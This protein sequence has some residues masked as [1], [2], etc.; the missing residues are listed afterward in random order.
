[1][2]V[3]QFRGVLI[4]GFHYY[5]FFTAPSASPSTVIV[6]E[7]TWSTISLQWEMVECL[8][9]NGDITGYSVQ[10]EEAG[11]NVVETKNLNIT[12]SQLTPFIEYSIS[13]AAVNANGIGVYTKNISVKTTG[14]NHSTCNITN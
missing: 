3:L 8:H 6:S 4:E 9:Q 1:M 14:T 13:V 2:E 5:M 12:L 11:T 7:V 10:Y